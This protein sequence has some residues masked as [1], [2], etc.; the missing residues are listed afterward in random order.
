MTEHCKE[1][2][3]RTQT[4]AE[5]TACLANLKRQREK[6]FDRMLEVQRDIY[7]QLESKVDMPTFKWIMSAVGAIAI[8]ILMTLWAQ[9]GTM[10]T[11][12]GDM[13]VIAAKIESEVEHGRQRN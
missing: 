5:N 2:E 11:M 3:S 1:H 4:I 12:Q 9:F 13:R 6:E 7:E 8:M 10:T